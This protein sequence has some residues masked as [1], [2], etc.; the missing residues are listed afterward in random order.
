M[1]VYSML[2]T[3]ADRLPDLLTMQPDWALNLADHVAVDSEVGFVHLMVIT[4]AAPVLY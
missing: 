2:L 1:L 3:W 4:A